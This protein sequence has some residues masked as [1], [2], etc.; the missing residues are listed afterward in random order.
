MFIRLIYNTISIF[1]LLISY[2]FKGI[3]YVISMLGLRFQ[4]I[5]FRISK[6][7]LKRRQNG[8]FK[9]VNDKHTKMHLQELVDLLQTELSNYKQDIDSQN[10]YKLEGM[11]TRSFNKGDLSGLTMFHTILFEVSAELRKILTRNR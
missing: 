2:L 3:T 8:E 6:A 9:R 10:F 4:E 7:N 11:I 1:T 5:N